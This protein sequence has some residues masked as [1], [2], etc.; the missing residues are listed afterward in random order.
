MRLDVKRQLF[1]RSERVKGIDFHPHEPWILTTL[2]SGHVYIWSYETQQIVKTFEL[3][4]VP[5]RAG[6]FVARKNWIVCGSDDFQLRVYNY[7]TSEK[8]TSFEAH[9]DYIRAIAIHPT[10]PF[11]LT[12]S[13]DM[14]I[15]LWDWDKAWKC[16]QVFEGHS[17]YVMGLA[18]NPKDTNTFASACLDR[19]V[20]I[21]SLGSP[22]PNFTLE[23]HDTKGVNHV[24]YYPHSDKPYL[25]TT[26]DDRTV[27]VW[28]YTTKS[29]IATLEGH[30]N[31]VSF[32]CYHPELPVII[33]G[34]EDG[35]IRI[36]HANTY[37]FEQSL[38]YGLE[39][40]WCVSYQKGK[41]GVAVGFDDGAV[42]VKLGREEPAVSMD[43]SG[44]LIWARHNEVV[45]AIIKGGDPNLKDNTTITLPTKDLGQCEVYPQTL[46]HSPNGRFVAVCG[47]GEYI[48]YTALAWRNKA[49]GSALDFVWGSKENSN[50]FAI[51]ES[52]TSV[53]VYK[54]FQEKSGGLDVG[55]QADG[56]TGGVLLGVKGQGGISF[57]DWQ[58]GGLVR[59]I[60]VE[61]KHV[62]WSDSGELVALACEDTFYVLRY[63][64]ENYVEAMQSGQIDE[65]GI[66]AAFEVITD[67]SESVRTGEWVGDCFIYT[68][69]TNRLN[70]LVGDQTY[71]VSHFDQPQYIL[72]YIQRDSRIYLADKDVNVTSFALSLPV[73]E[74]QTL[75]L[76]GDMETAEDLLPTIPSDQL[77]KVAR[78]LEGQGHKDLALEV[79][80][81]PEHKFELALAL[82]QL[83][84]ALDLAK[85]ADAD[86]KWKIVGDAALAGWNVP[87]ATECFS[88]AKDLGSLLLIYTSTNDKEG[89]ETLAR[90]AEESAAHNVAFTCR[91]LVGDVSGCVETLTKTGRHGEAVMFAQTY[92]PS[93]A[94]DAV[95]GWKESL[96]K[97]KKSRVAKMIGIPG[98]DD[99]LF[100]EWEEWLKLEK[101]GPAKADGE[102]EEEED[103]DGEDEDEDEDEDDE[104]EK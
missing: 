95:K 42:V 61:P 59:R 92:K 86:H 60:E 91:Y 39:R 69:S 22:V 81:D 67:I 18:I 77:N 10:Q 73:L 57:F 97:N 74:Y 85:E 25:L 98:D 93:L 90:Q 5:V 71:T 3:T 13:D 7:N 75:V 38:N 63:S 58:S 100:P 104:D 20:K 94:P 30:T 101:D 52:A 79:A 33:S 72:G 89:L 82:N 55:F 49:F 12:A 56:L 66:E 54:N 87:L 44:K 24:D 27:K 31:N 1:A 45:S 46:I 84:T 26:S 37:R 96:E 50:D 28:D 80:T 29:L 103:G 23:A 68:N 62:Y 34:S 14:T 6:R 51:R 2:Y 4:D 35:T 64:R 76:R 48:I 40:A 19:T 43:G 65:D 88:H 41:Q 17:H 102:A 16:V 8:I 32:A 36:W 53:K 15:K 70:Y 78:F 21:W 9:P 47:D 11:V 99:D 83:D